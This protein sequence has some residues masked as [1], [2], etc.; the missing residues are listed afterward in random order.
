MGRTPPRWADRPLTYTFVRPPGK[1]PS[2]TQSGP[3]HAER[4]RNILKD[5]IESKDPDVRIQA[6]VAG[7]MIGRGW[8]AA[9]AILGV[10]LIENDAGL[11]AA[12]LFLGAFTVSLTVGMV[13]RP[14]EK[15]GG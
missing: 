3:A 4:A 8:F 15:D 2:G 9:A 12:I 6:I 14:L 1:S 7:S 13:V 5:G 10:G 11:A